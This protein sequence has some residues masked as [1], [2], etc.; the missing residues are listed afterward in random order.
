MF[1]AL[2]LHRQCDAIRQSHG[3]SLRKALDAG[4]DQQLPGCESHYGNLFPIQRFPNLNRHG[5]D[6]PGRLIH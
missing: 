2:G 4:T 5:P 1:S 6:C 3:L